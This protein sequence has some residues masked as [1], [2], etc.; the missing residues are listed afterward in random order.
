MWLT[1]NPPL[2]VPRVP[3]VNVVTAIPPATLLGEGIRRRDTAEVNIPA[4]DSI[5]CEM[6]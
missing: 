4:Q 1:E 2:D 3:R 6:L 5:E